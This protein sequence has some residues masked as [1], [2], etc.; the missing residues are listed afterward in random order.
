MSQMTIPFQKLDQR[1]ARLGMTKTAVARRAGVSLPTVNRI[2]A[3]KELNPSL[4]N[5]HAMARALGVVI[6]LGGTTDIEFE[7]LQSPQEYRIRHARDKAKKLIRMVQGTMALE[8]Q[9]V[10]DGTVDDLVEDATHQLLSSMR[11]LWGE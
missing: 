6:R 10:D 4:S 1:R 11:R 8:A 3:G 7:E 9:A 2:L 5:L